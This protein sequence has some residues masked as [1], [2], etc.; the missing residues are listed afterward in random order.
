MILSIT[1]CPNL[2]KGVF[3]HNFQDLTKKRRLKRL[4]FGLDYIL[5]S[6]FRDLNPRPSPYHGDALPT[7]L[8]R[9]TNKKLAE[10][11]KLRI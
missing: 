2:K 5:W 3:S 4:F 11:S 10:T 6:R 7:E 9:P 1:K 8:K